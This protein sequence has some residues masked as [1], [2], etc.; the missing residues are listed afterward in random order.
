MVFDFGFE[1]RTKWH[2]AVFKK[3]ACGG[4][5]D[6]GLRDQP[7]SCGSICFWHLAVLMKDIPLLSEEVIL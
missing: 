7:F 2:S 6:L 1:D 5:G 3:A 4:F